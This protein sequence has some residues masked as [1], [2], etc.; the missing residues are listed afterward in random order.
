M[1]DPNQL[2]AGSR[3]T[4]YTPTLCGGYYFIGEKGFLTLHWWGGRYWRFFTT[5]EVNLYSFY[6]Y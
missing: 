5:K 2:S 6:S 1:H 4:I 3:N